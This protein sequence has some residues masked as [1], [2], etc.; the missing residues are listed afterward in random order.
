[1]FWL[2]AVL[3]AWPYQMLTGTSM[4]DDKF[5]QVSGGGARPLGALYPPERA[6]AHSRGP[7]AG[8]DNPEPA[9]TV[10]HFWLSRPQFFEYLNA[11]NGI[12]KRKDHRI[13]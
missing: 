3:M 13:F 4:T 12:R 9:R 11:L 5:E 1:M 2:K 10:V 6:P 8:A 7:S